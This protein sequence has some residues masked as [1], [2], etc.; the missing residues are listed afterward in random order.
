MRQFSNKLS[1]IVFYRLPV[2]ALCSFI[3]W[4]SSYPGIISEP[5]FAYDDKIFHFGIYAILA[6]LAARNLTVEKPLWSPAKIKTITILFACLYGVSDEIHQAF[7]TDRHAS[8][9]DLFADCAGSIAGCLF[10]INF[11]S[12]K[13]PRRG[14]NA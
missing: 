6:I 10:Y 13:T 7:V 9:W 11:V 12:K 2:I 8:L 3:F 4:Q 14:I 5:L 1:L